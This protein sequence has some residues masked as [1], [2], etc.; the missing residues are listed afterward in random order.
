[1]EP[2]NVVGMAGQSGL[3]VGGVTPDRNNPQAAWLW[4]VA[5]NLRLQAENAIA[6]AQE[7]L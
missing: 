3:A 7:L 4:I 1:M 6:V 2:P 5:D